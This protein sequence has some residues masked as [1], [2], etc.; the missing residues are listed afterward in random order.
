MDPEFTQETPGRDVKAF[1][2]ISDKQRRFLYRRQIKSVWFDNWIDFFR[3]PDL[4]SEW[5]FGTIFKGVMYFLIMMV[6]AVLGLIVM[7]P[8]T[9]YGL[10]WKQFR[11]YR[12]QTITT[13]EYI[14]LCGQYPGLDRLNPGLL[15][16]ARKSQETIARE[17]YP[18]KVHDWP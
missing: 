13:Y 11:A 18:S 2:D 16:N 15:E 5:I 14:R 1:V 17:R 4:G 8:K 6:I 3:T 12:G 10:V 7:I 9:I